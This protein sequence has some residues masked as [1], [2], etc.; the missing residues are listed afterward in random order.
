VD[1]G[2]PKSY[3]KYFGYFT[4]MRTIYLCSVDFGFLFRVCSIARSIALS[5]TPIVK[6][7]LDV[8]EL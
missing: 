6:R 7:Q 4:R 2:V 3:I 1:F 8:I 5:V